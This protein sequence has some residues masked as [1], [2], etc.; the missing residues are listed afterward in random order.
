[1]PA[2]CFLKIAQNKATCPQVN[3]GQIAVNTERIF[4]LHVSGSQLET[5]DDIMLAG[6]SSLSNFWS[7]I[8][9][10]LSIVS[11]SR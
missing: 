1:M 3:D 7:L 5:S 6:I 9:G 11:N 2:L 8:Y 4:L 10:Y